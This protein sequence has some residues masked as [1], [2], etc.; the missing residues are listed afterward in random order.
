M[1]I[2]KIKAYYRNNKPQLL[3]VVALTIGILW[4]ALQ[5]VI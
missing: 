1:N 4:S 2:R 5:P 3:F